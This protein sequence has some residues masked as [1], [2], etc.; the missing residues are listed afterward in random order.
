MNAQLTFWRRNVEFE[1]LTLTPPV[2]ALLTHRSRT[3]CRKASQPFSP[4][5]PRTQTNGGQLDSAKPEL[6]AFVALWLSA[7]AAI[8][9]WLA[10]LG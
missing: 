4:S 10:T 1:A 7:I 6:Y 8:A 2:A 3:A 5:R 9:L